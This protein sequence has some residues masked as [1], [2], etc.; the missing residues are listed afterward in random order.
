MLRS[1]AAADGGRCRSALSRVAEVSRRCDPRPPRTAAAAMASLSAELTKIK[2]LRS[3]AA[4]DGGRCQVAGIGLLDVQ[5]VAILGRRRRRP[6]PQGCRDRA[7]PCCGCDPRPPRTAAAAS[8]PK[9]SS[10]SRHCQLRSSAA[11]D[12]GRCRSGGVRCR[13]APGV[14]IL[15]RRGR[16][17]LPLSSRGR[18]VPHTGCDPRPP[19][20]A[21]A[22]PVRGRRARPPRRCCDPR[23]PR[24]AAAAGERHPHPQHADLVAILGRRG[25]RPLRAV[26]QPPGQSP[27]RVAILGR[28]GRRPL[29]TPRCTSPVAAPRV[30]ILGRRPLHELPVLNHG[31]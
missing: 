9:P 26:A 3:S 23:P 14:A 6:L 5:R 25:R 12:G 24:T 11:A 31:L 18:A 4:A 27:D 29:P 1:S 10:H 19:R 15:G 16:R 2:A 20:T 21:A 8:G 22:A 13:G 28:R 30:A 17:P 7:R